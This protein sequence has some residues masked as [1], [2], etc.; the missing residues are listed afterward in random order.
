MEDVWNFVIRCKRESEE[1]TAKRG[2]SS[3][4][5]DVFDQLPFFSCSNH[6]I[7]TDL[8]KDISRYLYCD[9]TK[10]PPYS[11]S[12]QDL[13]AIWKEKH[14]LIKSA[15]TILYKAKKDEMSKKHKIK[16]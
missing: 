12:Y 9:D 3:T 2:I 1:L 14:F 4:I 6:F 7:D 15:M 10:T 11:G 8:Q 5:K 13:P 16:G